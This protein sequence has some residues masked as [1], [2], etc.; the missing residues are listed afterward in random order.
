MSDQPG[1]N[2]GREPLSKQ[3]I[4]VEE[5]AEI[6]AFGGPMYDEATARKILQEVVLVSAEDAV[7]GEA[8]VGLDPNDAALNDFYFINFTSS[9]GEEITPMIYFACK[10]DVKMCR[11]LISRGASTTKRSERN[12]FL[13]PMHVAAR[14]GHLD[15]CKVLYANGGRNDVRTDR[16]DEDGW[17]PFHVAAIIDHDE[18]VRWLTLHGALCA[19]GS[20]D[21]VEGHR[22]YPVTLRCS[23]EEDPIFPEAWKR[24]RKGE[25]SSSCK[26]L[27]RWAKEVTQTHSALVM[28]LGGALPPAPDQDQ[29]RTLQCLSGHAGVR[30]HIG[31]FVGLEVTKRKHLRILHQAMDVLPSFVETDDEE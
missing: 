23:E 14:G 28:F 6:I 21:T 26:R 30:K 12:T 5:A 4:C 7:D 18:L 16:D 29:C 31:D 19:D 2:S 25:I 22:I 8:V 9:G 1:N 15:I 27:V 10:G 11:Y 20:S 3:H 13:Y 17:T 24:A